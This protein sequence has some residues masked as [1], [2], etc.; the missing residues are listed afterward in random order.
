MDESRRD[1]G[2]VGRRQFL[3]AGSLA[4]AGAALAG[5]S[6]GAAEAAAAPAAQDAPMPRV[7]LGRTQLQVSRLSIGCGQ[8]PT[9]ALLG[10]AFARGVNFLDT[11]EAYANGRSEEAVGELLQSMNR[12][13]QTVIVSKGFGGGRAYM[14]SGGTRV[15]SKMREEVI[16]S[17]K[18]L[19]T[20]YIDIYYTHA[21]FDYRTDSPELLFGEGMR[22]AV[23]DLKNEG[24]IRHF[25]MSTH[26]R[27]DVLFDVFDRIARDDLLDVVMFR[28]N[29][30]VYDE[31]RLSACIDAMHKAGIGLIGMKTQGGGIALPDRVKPFVDRGFSPN[32]AALQWVL[33]DSR[34]HACVSSMDNV[35]H[36]K[37]NVEAV[38]H[39]VLSE[40]GLR[41][42]HMYAVATDR[43][44][45]TDCGKCLPVCPQ[46]I[47][48]SKILRYQM[49]HDHYGQAEKGREGYGFL[50]ESAR[51][52]RC[53]CQGACE[54]V[55]PQGIP[56]RRKL[57]R[58]G[59][60]LIG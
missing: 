52:D 46:G 40:S 50:P 54:E 22:R 47:E 39:P 31:K 32:Q 15:P 8:P 3:G 53:N 5:G 4:L 30:R 60:V 59:K 25:G 44:Y 16:A 35:D 33:A 14:E 43:D 27:G 38:K 19:R 26:A 34:I 37:Q 28:Y 41:S 6:A 48:I 49:Y 13:K 55:C 42:L 36:V 57:R 11:S 20:D 9:R 2:R 24:L 56:I 10:T 23:A 18:R 29:F 17:C 7:T 58:A 45:C 21:F 51:A 12:R 1:A